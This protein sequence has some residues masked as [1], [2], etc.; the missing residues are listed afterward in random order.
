MKTHIARSGKVIGEYLQEA[1]VKAIS[2][3]KIVPTDYWWRAGMTNWKRVEEESPIIKTAPAIVEDV[4]TPIP[5]ADDWRIR[6]KHIPSNYGDRPATY[7]QIELIKRAGLTDIV[8]LTKYDAS[9]WIDRILEADAGLANLREHQLND[10]LGLAGHRTPSGKYKAEMQSCLTR[11]ERKRAEIA[12]DIEIEPESKKWLTDKLKEKERDFKD[13][14]SELAKQRVD[15]WL[16]VIKCGRAKNEQQLEDLIC[17]E[18]SPDF[19]SVDPSLASRLNVLA[20]SF[21]KLPT[22][23]EIKDALDRLDL[24]SSTWD[25][26]QP[27]LL[28]R[29]LLSPSQPI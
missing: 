4:K 21:A 3:G 25:D 29:E 27:E 18:A 13:S 19:N 14:L 20:R 12:R 9:R 28:L 6:P 23:R 2:D 26:D 22:K 5:T 24:K 7:E 1:L 15:Y 16:W 8:G 10:M 11:L 17:F